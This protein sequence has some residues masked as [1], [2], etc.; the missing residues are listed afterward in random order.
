[1]PFAAAAAHQNNK[2]GQQQ[3]VSDLSAETVA[4]LAERVEA[5]MKLNAAVIALN[6]QRAASVVG[7]IGYG[8]GLYRQRFPLHSNSLFFFMFLL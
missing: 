5:D 3:L 6:A 7:F 2:R 8:M 1:M 4:G